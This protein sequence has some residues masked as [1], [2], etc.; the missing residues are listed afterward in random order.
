MVK[1]LAGLTS[2]D[3]FLQGKK[4]ALDIGAGTAL[5]VVNDASADTTLILN[6]LIIVGRIVLELIDRRKQRRKAR[7]VNDKK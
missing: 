1:N 7:N 2:A 4:V 3:T 6:A 5:G